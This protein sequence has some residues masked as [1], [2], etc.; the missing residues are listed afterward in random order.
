MWM[1]L[2]VSSLKY[3]ENFEEDL[4]K[5]NTSIKLDDDDDDD[6]EIYKNILTRT[7]SEV[8]RNFLSIFVFCV[9]RQNHHHL[10]NL[11]EAMNMMMFY[12]FLCEQMQWEL[13]FHLR[14]ENIKTLNPSII[15]STRHKNEKKTVHFVDDNNDEKEAEERF[16]HALKQRV[17]WK[18][19][20]V[21]R[22]CLREIMR[23][24]KKGLKNREKITQ[25]S[26]QESSHPTRKMNL[27]VDSATLCEKCIILWSWRER[28]F[29]IKKM[30]SREKFS[31]YFLSTTLQWQAKASHLIIFFFEKNITRVE[32]KKC[33]EKSTHNER[34]NYIA[35]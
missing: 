32:K 4:M 2:L 15:I 25:F 14:R 18:L 21:R 16:L 8:E 26:I 3:T 1:I 33:G 17:K 5:H 24:K 31:S 9:C 19:D 30:L 6:D 34:E 35:I 23:R 22:G 11:L 20:R 13:K 28:I 12:C 29:Y 7:Q 27:K 10:N